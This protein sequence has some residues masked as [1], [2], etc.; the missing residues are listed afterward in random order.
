MDTHE[1]PHP[2]TDAPLPQLDETG[3]SRVLVVVAHPDDAEYG[4]SAAVAH[5]VSRGIEVGY[6]LLTAGEAGMQRPPEEA[7]PLRAREQ[8]AACEAVG[9]ERLTILDFPDGVL[10]YGLDLRRAIA[11]EI[12]AFRPDAVVCGAGELVVEWG[13][14]HADHR[15]A[16]L[17]TIDAVR[18]ADNRWVFPELLHEEDLAPWGAS[19][20]LLTG[21]RPTHCV[22]VDEEAER[23]AVA[24]LGAHEAYL[25]DLPWHP[26]PEELVTGVLAQQGALAGVPRGVAFA[27]H[28]L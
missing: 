4:T 23:R 20:L 1:A 22:V 10:E 24:S 18:D 2:G 5:W 12:R 8:R 15:A 21:T 7:G 27:E 13:F 19:R 3:L 16:G 14:D 6:L 28:R 9:V 25:A 17:A 11:R 26:S